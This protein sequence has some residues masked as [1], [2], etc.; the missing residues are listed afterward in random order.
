MFVVAAVVTMTGC[1]GGDY[2]LAGDSRTA[3]PLPATVT[4]N[5]AGQLR[6]RATRDRDSSRTRSSDQEKVDLANRARFVA[7]LATIADLRCKVSGPEPDAEE[8]LRRALDAARDA[9]HTRG[10][11]ERTLKWQDADLIAG[12]AVALMIKRLP[13]PTAK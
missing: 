13:S 9:E 2:N 11:Y 3:A 1:G 8:I 12:E 10:F 4:C 7:T 6:D 5:D